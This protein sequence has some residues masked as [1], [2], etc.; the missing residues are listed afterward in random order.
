M[1]DRKTAVR[2][3]GAGAAATIALGLCSTGAANADTFVPL[4][5]GE[6]SRTLTDG[7]VVTVRLVGESATINPSMGSTP[8]HRNTWVSGSAQVEL[9]GPGVK[10]G[11]IYPGYV[12]GCQVNIG[13]G[14]VTGGVDAKSDWEAG[15][16]EIGGKTGGNL[17]LGPG[18]AK[19]MYLLDLEEA[20][21]YGDES[22]K[23]RNRFSGTSGSVTWSDS[24]I[25]LSGCAGYAQARAF[26]TVKVSTEAV[27]SV[28]T[29]WGQPFSIG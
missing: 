21:D 6:I 10:G 2:L 12:V 23:T 17:S 1:I 7:T 13:G 5:G 14:G 27:S 8:V 26:V 20:D 24:T 4:P 16:P 29:L 11:A 28:V 25:G 18:Q 15:K 19:A 22:H 3:A 9:S